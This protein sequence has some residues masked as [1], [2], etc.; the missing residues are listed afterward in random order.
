MTDPTLWELEWYYLGDLGCAASPASA[1][2]PSEAFFGHLAGLEERDLR[3]LVSPDAETREEPFPVSAVRHLAGER[4]SAECYPWREPWPKALRV[5]F[6]RMPPDRPGEIILGPTRLVLPWP[7]ALDAEDAP[8]PLRL[9]DVPEVLARGEGDPGEGPDAE[10]E[11]YV[12]D[13]MHLADWLVRCH[14]DRIREHP[15]GARGAIF[16]VIR[17]AGLDHIR[18][19]RSLQIPHEDS[20]PSDRTRVSARRGGLTILLGL[21]PEACPGRPHPCPSLDE[22]AGLLAPGGEKGKLFRVWPCGAWEP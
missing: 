15:E 22:L 10:T 8:E 2:S 7:D 1:Y 14:P 16:D 21:G 6:R 17:E 4:P 13:V 11:L 9:L 3:A 12:S 20:L 18:L 5:Y 19:P